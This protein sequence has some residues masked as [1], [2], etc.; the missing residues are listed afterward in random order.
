MRFSVKIFSITLLIAMQIS[1]FAVA[2]EVFVIKTSDII[3]YN[4]CV[5]GLR[6]ALSA[7]SFEVFNMEGDLEKGRELISVLKDNKQSRVIIAVGPQ[8][9]FVI[10]EIN[11]KAAKLFCMVLN[12]QKVIP[13]EK[14]YPGVSL[15]IPVSYQLKQ[16]KSAFPE[17]KRIGV[18]FSLPEN[19]RVIESLQQEAVGLGLSIVGFPITTAGD[20]LPAIAS[21][22]YSIDIL[23][24]VP[25]EKINSQKIVEYIIKESLR[26]KIPVVGY[27]SWFAKNGAILS[28]LIDYRDVG[29]Q[30]GAM[31]AQLFKAGSTVGFERIESPA[32]IKISIDMKTA[33]KLGIQ[34]SAASI[35]QAS[36]VIR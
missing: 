4:T 27:N 23:L 15:N 34:I 19:E 35:Q 2:E 31:A 17:R 14:R 32:K 12:P 30:A 36:E 21:N 33:E 26:R 22:N 6:D 11:Y 24:M 10:S 13:R 25:D 20:I 18:F 16:I 3:P 9:A 5:E 7:Y 8:A 1:G 29:L 28:F